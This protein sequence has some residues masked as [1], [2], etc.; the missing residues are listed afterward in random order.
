MQIKV[1]RGTVGFNFEADNQPYGPNPQ[2]EVAFDQLEELACE[3]FMSE[4]RGPYGLDSFVS[5]I[6]G[7]RA[8][9][10]GWPSS[11]SLH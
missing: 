2:K 1:N 8:E 7:A 3:I 5:A 11:I 6:K 4:Y 10:R 9:Y